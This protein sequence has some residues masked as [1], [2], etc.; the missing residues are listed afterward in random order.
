MSGTLGV[1]LGV[2]RWMPK[3]RIILMIRMMK[4]KKEM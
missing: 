1:G 4:R 2:E 3:K